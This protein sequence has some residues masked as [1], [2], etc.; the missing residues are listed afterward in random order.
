MDGSYWCDPRSSSLFA[1]SRTVFSHKTGR[2][3]FVPRF[4][5]SLT[6]TRTHTHT[7]TKGVDCENSLVGLES[8][9][10]SPVA[11]RRLVIRDEFASR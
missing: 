2:F 11:R 1:R 9:R 6:R 10:V 3:L 5:P 8:F 4:L 7:Y